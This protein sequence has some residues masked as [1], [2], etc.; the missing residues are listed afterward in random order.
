MSS[1]LIMEFG[2]SSSSLAQKRELLSI[3]DLNILSHLLLFRPKTRRPGRTPSPQ[4]VHSGQHDRHVASSKTTIRWQ[5]SY[6]LALSLKQTSAHTFIDNFI[7]NLLRISL[8]YVKPVTDNVIVYSSM[9]LALW[10]LPQLMD[11]SIHVRL[12]SNVSLI[13]PPWLY[14][15]IKQLYPACFVLSL[16]ILALCMF[17]LCDITLCMLA[18]FMHLQIVLFTLLYSLYHTWSYLLCITVTYISLFSNVF[19][20]CMSTCCLLSSIIGGILS[21]YLWF[22]HINI[23]IFCKLH[24]LSNIIGNSLLSMHFWFLYKDT[25][26]YNRLL[27]TLHP[28]LLVWGRH[29]LW[30]AGS[31]AVMAHTFILKTA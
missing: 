12:V 6:H 27:F 7:D 5:E 2:K 20:P 14:G 17:H 15:L 3:L 28:L 10:S 18:I 29:P 26:F 24:C 22:F 4:L 1:N 13:D 25:Q 21:V 31:V 11:H 16:K 9:V 23:Y 19:K 8:I 30:Q